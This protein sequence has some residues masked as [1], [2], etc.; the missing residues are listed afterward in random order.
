[1]SDSGPSRILPSE[2]IASAVSQLTHSLRPDKTFMITDRN[3]ARLHTEIVDSLSPHLAAPAMV[4]PPGEV[5]KNIDTLQSVWR[6]LSDSG[7]TRRSILLCLGGGTITDLG[8]F[9]AACFK[10]GM[11]FINIPTTLLGAVDAAVGGKTGIDFN[12]FK[13]EIGTFADAEAV[14]VSSLPYSTLPHTELL[15]GFAEIVKTALITPAGTPGVG[16]D[17][18]RTLSEPE[19]VLADPVLL[20]RVVISSINAK[21]AVVHSDRMEQGP[22]K[23]LNFGHTFGHAVESLALQAGTPVP[24]GVAVAYGM[25]RALEISREML[26][27]DPD[28]V[29]DY[30]EK[31]MPLYPPLPEACSD[32]EGIRRFMAHDKK[33]SQQDI[34]N[35]TLLRKQGE[36]VVDFRIPLDSPVLAI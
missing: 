35:F 8:G 26:N 23:A 31:I 13:N 5:C 22:R 25:L 28:V 1:M 27:L 3:V 12:G 14:V 18:F 16:Q 21:L 20:Q 33:N 9:A 34:V 17:L 7:A 6:F 29:S 15:S 19:E 36:P 4:L 2:N 30:R 24:H 11:R 32:A 10:R